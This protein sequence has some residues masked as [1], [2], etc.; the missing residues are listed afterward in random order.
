MSKSSQLGV[1]SLRRSTPAVIITPVCYQSNQ[2]VTSPKLQSLCM[3]AFFMECERV[4]MVPPY[5]DSN[6]K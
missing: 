3:A 2:L 4:Y 5:T 6:R 1:S